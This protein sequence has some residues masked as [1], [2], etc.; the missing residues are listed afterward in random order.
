MESVRCLSAKDFEDIMVHYVER[1]KDVKDPYRRLK[2]Y[3]YKKHGNTAFFWFLVVLE[4]SK[5]QFQLLNTFKKD[6]AD[7]LFHLCCNIMPC[8]WS[9]TTCIPAVF[10]VEILM[11]LVD[12]IKQHK[13][14][15]SVAHMC[16]SLP[17]PE[18]TMMILLT[19]DSFKDHFTSTHHPK[20]YTLFHLAV[21]LK[22]VAKCRIILECSDFLGQD[23]GIFVENNEK[24]SSFQLATSLNAKECV[25]FLMESQSQSWSKNS[26]NLLEQLQKALKSKKTDTVRKM[27][28]AA[29]DLVKESF[30]DGCSCLHKAFDHQVR[31]SLFHIA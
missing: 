12:L 14:T 18:E 26:I 15:W 1:G 25:V 10:T 28:E 13:D 3:C 29:P 23:P 2:L 19:S 5:E 22:S 9:V 7:D 20:G 6:E 21:E 8:F 30:L 24:M 11:K 31:T 17:L 16:V 4:I 27:I